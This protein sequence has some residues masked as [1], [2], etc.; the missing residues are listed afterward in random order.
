[1]G[2]GKTTIGPILANTIG[3]D[4]VDTDRAIEKQLGK[5]VSLVYKEEGEKYFR[6]VERGMLLTL[7][8]R[9]RVVISLGGGTIAD[10]QNLDLIKSSGIVIYL[11]TTPEQLFQRLQ[12]KPDRPALRD[13][14]GEKLNDVALR[15]RITELYERREPFYSKAD[16]IVQTD[17]ARVGLTVDHIVKMLARY[18]L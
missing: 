11:R 6:A 13:V 4:F 9:K 18:S 12:H 7:S 16:I 8:T 2:S 1:M 3:F 15:A 10:D 17:S 14:D 5:S